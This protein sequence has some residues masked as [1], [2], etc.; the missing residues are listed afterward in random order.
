MNHL[1]PLEAR[2]LFSGR[3]CRINAGGD[4][5]VDAMGK[6]WQADGYFTGGVARSYSIDVRGTDEDQL[7]ASQRAG[8]FSYAVP[9]KTGT[10]RVRLLFCDG[11]LTAGGQ[12]TINVFAEKMLK[13]TE[14]DIAAAGGCGTAFTK[15][16][17]V[18]VK[19]R[20]LNLW[21]E[22]VK[23][24]AI[25]SGIEVT[26]AQH[27]TGWKALPPAPLARFE[28]QSEVVN[29]ELLVF[30]GFVSASG[31]ATNQ[32]HAY[33][34]DS[35]SWRRLADLPLAQTHAGCAADGSAIYL[36]G[37][38][39]GDWKGTHTQVSRNVYKYDLVTNT[40]TSLLPLPAARAAGALV[41]VGRKL[42]FFGGVDKR[43]RDRGSHWVLDLRRPVKW[44]DQAPLPNP[45]NHLGY[46]LLGTRIYAIGGQH[47]LN[48]ENDNVADVHAF[49][50]ITG[51]WSQVASLPEP[52]S[53]THNSTFVSPDSHLIIAG[54]ATN[55][56]VTLSDLLEYDPTTDK[57]SS[58]G[59][60]PE[61]RAAP[62]VKMLGGRIVLTGGKNEGPSEGSDTWSKWLV[63]ELPAGFSESSVA[64]LNT[65]VAA[66]MAFAPDGRLF[67][68]DSTHGEIRVV[69][70]GALRA[71]PAITLTVDNARE[72]G[73][74][75]LAFAPNFATAARGEKYLFVYYTR[76][77][78]DKP[79]TWPSNATNRLSRFTFT[80]NDSSTLDPA[81]ELVLLD[82][83]DA[84][85]GTHN[86]GALYFGDDGMLYL[87]VGDADVPENAQDLSSL[88]GKVLRLNAMDPCHLIPADNPFVRV[89]AARPE[90]WAY[91]LRNPFSGA[92]KRGADTFYV[93][94]V[95][96]SD[97]EEIDS[98][99]KGS[100][101]G[102]PLSEGASS[103]PG[104]EK[105]LFAYAHNGQSSAI[106]GGTFYSG[107]SLPQQYQGAFFFGDYVL[108]TIS[109]L[110]EKDD[111][112][113]PFATKTLTIVDIDV[114]PIDG[115]LWYLD[116]A[117]R[118]QKIKYDATSP[119]K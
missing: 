103:L 10:Y 84:N 42:H 80:S 45:R 83:I 95:G 22:G 118:V 12:R 105:P 88:N 19:D 106:A 15:T 100:N 17:N 49:D 108:R 21:F 23:D 60:L 55:S 41:R 33:N 57:W 61:L 26:P 79:N 48:E 98:I 47:R 102:W 31:V 16:F 70:R 39:V 93:N 85:S 113:L 5:F 109:T 20:H 59:Q 76:P 71:D 91:G 117:G 69:E 90:I 94:D 65:D 3:T 110:D 87:G 4:Q 75:G 44:I 2:R 97:Q 115:S 13:L 51:T 34:A 40:W 46:A 74:N 56:T 72:R 32:V 8:N 52:R 96:G 63:P 1:E 35:D 67:V 25:V 116:V 43:F 81:S 37:G 9:V 111:I 62:S 50:V 101:Y 104:Q 86:G 7:F 99:K 30:G 24:N 6:S 29:H 107:D 28:G 78:P 27:V 58:F 92:F 82:N 77:D 54:G 64:N 89:S 73:I 38:Y 66:T 18:N 68:G 119:L 36:A 11:D 114:N 14:F 53:H 112:A